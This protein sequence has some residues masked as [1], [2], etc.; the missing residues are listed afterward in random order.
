G[1]Q[2]RVASPAEAIRDG[3]DFIVIG[4]AIT[5]SPDPRAAAERILGEIDKGQ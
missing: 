1:D 5:E 3:A 4:R 2:K